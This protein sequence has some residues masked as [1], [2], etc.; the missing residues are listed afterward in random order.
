MALLYRKQYKELKMRRVE[1]MCELL[2]R[3]ALDEGGDVACADMRGL[4]DESD[5]G[6]AMV[7]AGAPELM[8]VSRMPTKRARNGD[9]FVC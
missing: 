7:F 9:S 6:G 8:V 4:L 2:Q 3:D 1:D 5:E